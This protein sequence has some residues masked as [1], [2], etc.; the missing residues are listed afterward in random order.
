MV[1]VYN[2]LSSIS[3]AKP[4]PLTF[5]DLALDWSLFLDDKDQT[6]FLFTTTTFDDPMECALD[7]DLLD[8]NLHCPLA[9][10]LACPLLNG[11]PIT[12]PFA[13]LC[14]STLL[15]SSYLPHYMYM[16]RIHVFFTILEVTIKTAA[17][18]Y[19]AKLVG[20]LALLNVEVFLLLEFGKSA[21]ILF[22]WAGTLICLFLILLWRWSPVVVSS[23]S[24]CSQQPSSSS[25]STAVDQPNPATTRIEVELPPEANNNYNFDKIVLLRPPHSN[26][27]VKYN[28][29]YAIHSD[30]ARV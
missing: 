5:I 12:D 18:L 29:T 4:H 19:V 11:P 30:W 3:T 8:H 7:E 1:V 16:H 20:W 25:S 21:D 10:P 9:C 17:C 22:R 28:K 24:G 2:I 23:R 13:F 15:G 27:Y 6:T 26:T 14:E